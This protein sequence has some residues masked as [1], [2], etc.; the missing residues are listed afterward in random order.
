MEGTCVDIHTHWYDQDTK[1]LKVS[2][3]SNAFQDHVAY[4]LSDV[5]RKNEVSIHSLSLTDKEEIKK[6]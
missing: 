4:M 6:Q 5:R 3:S 2:K 1:A